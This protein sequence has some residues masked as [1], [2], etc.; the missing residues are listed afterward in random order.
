MR[1]WQSLLGYAQGDP[2]SFIEALM[3]SLA[4]GL[5]LIWGFTTQW[6]YLVLALS[7]GIGAASS[8]LSRIHTLTYRRR[9][10]SQITATTIIILSCVALVD[11]V[12]YF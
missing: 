11:L 7:Y 5:L 12:A 4:L 2:F 1:L 3:L 6:P 10:L 9:H 8:I